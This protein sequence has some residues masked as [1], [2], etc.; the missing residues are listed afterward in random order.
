MESSG[1]LDIH[2][3]VCP[4]GD[5]G[6]QSF[7]EAVELCRMAAATGTRLLFA[8]PHVLRCPDEDY[9]LTAEREA[10]VRAT[11]ALLAEEA[12]AFGLELRLGWELGP[13]TPLNSG[14]ERVQLEGTR[15][16]LVEAP[17]AWYGLE[18]QL[19]FDVLV[20][21]CLRIERQ[22]LVPIVAH[23]ERCASIIASPKLALVLAEHG[24][25]LQVN[26]SS[27][28]GGHGTGAWQT[29][30]TLLRLGLYDFIGSDGH[31][32][33]MRPPRL[34]LAYELVASELCGARADALFGGAA[35]ARIAL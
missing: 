12:A 7:A 23:P 32:T 33:E 4:S 15:A 26:A 6:A 24:W 14:Y 28:T 2:S 27:L 18:P 3:H 16:V 8:T 35:F 11:H 34:D 31:D 19:Y 13:G 22:G 9:L 17:G 21:E 29:A 5:D 20:G 10:A 30:W 25:P 1:F